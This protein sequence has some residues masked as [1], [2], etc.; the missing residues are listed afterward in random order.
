MTDGDLFPP[1]DCAHRAGD[2]DLLPPPDPTHRIAC[3]ID[4]RDLRRLDLYAALTAAGI[5]PWPGDREA[6]EQL[7]ALPTSVHVALHRWLGSTG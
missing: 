3:R 1:R 7:S 4:P 6:V 5:A 2:G